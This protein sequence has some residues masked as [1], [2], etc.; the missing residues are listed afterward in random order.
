MEAQLIIHGKPTEGEL[1][2]VGMFEGLEEKIYADFFG[3]STKPAVSPC[4]VFEIR[5]W[6]GV[7]YSVYSYYSDGKDKY[8][9]GNG[10]CVV[11]LVVRE[12]ISD[13]YGKIMTM[14]HEVY[15]HIL[16]AQ[17]NV[18]DGTGKYLVSSLRG[19]IE[20]SML[21]KTCQSI[22]SMVQWRNIPASY[23]ISKADNEPK[24]LNDTDA[25]NSYVGEIM[26]KEGKVHI[27]HQF[28][29]ISERQQKQKEEE[30][31]RSGLSVGNRGQMQSDNTYNLSDKQGVLVE[32]IDKAKD[33]IIRNMEFL[34]SNYVQSDRVNN[35]SNERGP[36]APVR[37]P[38]G[39]SLA[40]LAHWLTL[41]N[42]GLLLIVGSHTCR[43][44][45]D[46]SQSES[47]ISADST[48]VESVTI[49]QSK[50]KEL[51]REN[52]SLKKE[53]DSLNKI[54]QSINN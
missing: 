31:K 21:E 26:K 32:R 23:T 3:S 5:R 14:L 2:S 11:S 48:K 40:R 8:G 28:I 53:K 51:Q 41:A 20:L 4:Y 6:K 10:Y 45:L 17:L 19:S 38:R 33:D 30:K 43:G 50:L 49:L 1:L 47:D 7:L 52:T 44:N 24:G 46:E 18:I 22:M 37:K 16:K 9:S 35:D 42:F 34:L 27:S 13:E 15:S 12:K 25:T 39:L 36:N 29:S 54:I